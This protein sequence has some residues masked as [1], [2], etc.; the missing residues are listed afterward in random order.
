MGNLP[1]A[2][3]QHPGD[4]QDLALALVEYVIAC[5]QDLDGG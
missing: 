4:A 5:M 2:L 1:A 3:L